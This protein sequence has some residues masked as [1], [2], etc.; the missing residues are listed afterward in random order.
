M[1]RLQA[2]DTIFELIEVCNEITGEIRQQL[3]YFKASVYKDE[4]AK[5]IEE[6][7]LSLRILSRLIVGKN[8]N[9][10][11]YDYDAKLSQSLVSSPGECQLSVRVLCL[12]GNVENELKRANKRFL[13][14]GWDYSNEEF[15][16][17]FSSYRQQILNCCIPGS[18]CWNLVQTLL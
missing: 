9:D 14:K 8:L 10:L 18:H 11:F 15:I 7:I 2:S 13:E 6:K 12:L 17:Y 1:G 16:E 4:I 3:V 5:V